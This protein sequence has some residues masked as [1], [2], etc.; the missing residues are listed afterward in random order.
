VGLRTPQGFHALYFDLDQ[1]LLEYVEGF[2]AIVKRRSPDASRPPANFRLIYSNDWYEVWR[3]SRNSPRVIEHVPL[4]DVHQAALAP[5]CRDVLALAER[6]NE[7]DRLVAAR[8]PPS[9]ELDTVSTRRS[10]SWVTHPWM[11]R[12]V[13][14]PTP[15]S[16]AVKTV[17]VEAPGRYRAWVRGSFGRRID[18]I[19]DGRTIGE[20]RG[21]NNLGQWL[22]G[23]TVQLDAGRHRLQLSRP[24][25]SVSPGDGYRGELGPLVLEPVDDDVQLERVPPSQARRLCG[26]S[27]DWI[28]LVRPQAGSST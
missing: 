3:R 28:E 8:R 4:Q 13:L 2:S 5:P 21:V 16:T 1:Q 15:G 24:G 9:V 6:A 14:T 12:M 25:G 17:E 23:G 27:W 7:G 26:R 22:P 11:P 19:V 10:P 20:A 18:V